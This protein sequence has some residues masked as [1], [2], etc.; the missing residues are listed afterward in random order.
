MATM[1]TTG[2]AFHS[3][4]HSPPSSSSSSSGPNSLHPGSNTTTDNIISNDTFVL[5]RHQFLHNQNMDLVASLIPTLLYLS[6]ILVVGTAGNSVVLAVYCRR[7]RPSVTRTYIVAISICG[8]L[9]TTLSVPAELLEI[10]YYFTFTDAWSCKL[11]RS[12][13]SFF[14]FLAACILVAVALER[15]SKICGP[16]FR[17]LLS[18]RVRWSLL[19][20]VLYSALITLPYTV[21]AGPRTVTF[22]GVNF[23]GFRCSVE[24]DYVNTIVHVMHN[25]CAGMTFIMCF[26]IILVSYVRIARRIWQHQQRTAPA[27]RTSQTSRQLRQAEDRNRKPSIRV[28]LFNSAINDKIKLDGGR[29]ERSKTLMIND[30][31]D[32]PSDAVP[33]PHPAQQEPEES[34]VAAPHTLTVLKSDSV[35]DD[36]SSLQPVAISVGTSTDRNRENGLSASEV[37]DNEIFASDTDNGNSML[38]IENGISLSEKDNEA[39]VA[40]NETENME[41]KGGEEKEGEKRR[42]NEEKAEEEEEDGETKEE[43]KRVSEEERDKTPT[44]PQTAHT[45]AQTPRRE[46]HTVQGESNPRRSKTSTCTGTQQAKRTSKQ[47]SSRSRYKPPSTRRIPTKTT[48]TLFVLTIMSVFINYFPYMLMTSLSKWEDRLSAAMGKNGYHVLLRSYFI[49]TIFN[50]L[51]LF[52]CSAPF[53]H[54]C[55]RLFSVIG[56]KRAGHRHTTLRK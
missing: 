4:R 7:F 27:K 33:T 28:Q 12:V 11:T 25:F 20:C 19:G 24:D 23:S 43:K 3:L 14:S 5:D 9:T 49:H 53:R 2:D 1:E 16:Y 22:P 39:S 44:L 13:K 54:E 18:L 17:R 15:H 30:D 42:T 35:S 26:V 34:S 55:R 41:E 10:R 8:L 45:S 46:S 21:I 52:F 38:E 31:D 51:V 56:S 40:E 32:Q 36:Y 47:D 50:P 48:F 37:N 29:G 6:F